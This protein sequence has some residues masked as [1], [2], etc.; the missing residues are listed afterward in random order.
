LFAPIFAG[1]PA[2]A[3]DGLVAFEGDLAWIT[4]AIA[5]ILILLR[6]VQFPLTIATLRRGRIAC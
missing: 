3:K 5:P 6:S 2:S 1:S 4:L